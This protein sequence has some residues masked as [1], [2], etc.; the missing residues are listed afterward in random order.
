MRQLGGSGMPS[1]GDIGDWI[2]ANEALLSGAAA[3][4]ALGGV[5]LSPLGSAVR[6]LLT[7][8]QAGSR[9]IATTGQ[10]AATAPRAPGETILA[11]LAFDNQSS[12]PE[13][14]FFSDGVSEEIIQRLARGA[15][16]KVIGRASSFQFRGERKAEAAQS[17]QCSHVLDGSIRR[18][19][20]RVRISAHLVEA[21]SRTTLWSDRYDRG[22]EDLFAVQDEIAESIA[23]ALDRTFSRISTRA[24][25]PSVYD[26]Y[27]RAQPRSYA[28]DELRTQIGLLE[29]VTQRAPQFAEAWGRLAYLR[30]WL[31]FYQPF[32]ERPASAA[33]VAVEANRALAL[34][35]D[36]TDA[37]AGQLFVLPPFGRF[38]ETDAALD[39]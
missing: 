10:A 7:R 37:I 9:A 6:R 11:V 23:E 21:S 34:D 2:T 17:L 5:V 29:V 1:I 33:R 39:A 31:H 8:K 15:K 38:I 26:L 12:D 27:L 19:G 20:E 22:L 13:M 18:S 28:P 4:V 14:Q 24:V 16:L 3:L 36:N 25:D 35:P 30:A 32:A